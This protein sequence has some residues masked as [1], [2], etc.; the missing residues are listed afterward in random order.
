MVPK[1]G[2]NVA[3]LTATPERSLHQRL[4]ALQK[5]NTV[6]TKRAELKKDLKVGRAAIHDLLLDPP[7]V[8]LTAKVADLLVAVPKCGCVKAGKI[9]QQCRISPS[10]TIGGL[11]ARQRAE[12]VGHLR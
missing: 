1:R 8:I 6:R 10:R 7:D 4:E 3:T 9:L 12:I 2:V 5:A 11:S